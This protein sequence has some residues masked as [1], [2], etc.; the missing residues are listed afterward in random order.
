[1]TATGNATVSTFNGG[2]IDIAAIKTL[3]IGAGTSTGAITG[4]GSIQQDWCRHINSLGCKYLL[5][6]NDSYSR[7]TYH[8]IRFTREYFWYRGE[9]WYFECGR[10]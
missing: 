2:S 5:R 7:Y 4:S 8:F 6:Y 1:L 9:R 3:S 10:L